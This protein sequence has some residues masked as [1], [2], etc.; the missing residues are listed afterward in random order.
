MGSMLLPRFPSTT[1]RILYPQENVHK[2]KK[3]VA[4]PPAQRK[5]A[6]KDVN[7][8]SDTGSSQSLSI[9]LGAKR[10]R[11]NPTS[12]CQNEPLNSS[13]IETR[14]GDNTTKNT[15]PYSSATQTPNSGLLVARGSNTPPDLFQAYSALCVVDEFCKQQPPG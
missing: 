2:R 6:P 13:Q 5:L 7:A 4:A 12:T 11:R 10:S 1:S 9:T 8:V 15:T 3:S 14:N